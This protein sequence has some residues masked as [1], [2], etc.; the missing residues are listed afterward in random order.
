MEK[1]PVKEIRLL[2]KMMEQADMGWWRADLENKTFYCSDY[3]AKLF[4]LNGNVITYADF[5]HL[6][7]EDYRLLVNKQFMHAF[8][9]NLY[10]EA[11]P[12]HTIQG[13]RWIRSELV[14]V[15]TNADGQP[16]AATGFTKV[17]DKVAPEDLEVKEDHNRFHTLVE[18]TRHIHNLLQYIPVGYM[19]VHLLSYTDQQVVDYLLVDINPTGAD[20]L[21]R[22]ASESIGKTAREL[23]I[24]VPQ[25]SDAMLTAMKESHSE[26]TTFFK[27]S[28]RYCQCM[29]YKADEE[30]LVVLFF[31]VSNQVRATDALDQSEK[32]LRRVYSNIPVGI[33]VYNDKGILIELNQRQMD[34]LGISSKEDVL[35]VCLFD[36]P[37]LDQ[38]FLEKLER[39]KYVEFSRKFDFSKVGP[40]FKTSKKQ[41]IIDLE[42]NFTIIHDVKGQLIYYLAV[43]FD[44]TEENK[45]KN[46]I[47]EFE[48]FFR[49]AGEQAQVGYAYFNVLT[50]EGYAQNTWYRNIGEE[51]STPLSAILGIYSHLHPDAREKLLLLREET[52]T[53]E[54]DMI[55]IEV[56]VCRPDG[57]YTW[58]NL[59]FLVQDY[60][61]QERVIEV[62][63]ITYDITELKDAQ[64]KLQI[65]KEK[66]EEANR[67]KSA[68]LAN[69]SHEIRTPL[70]AIIGFSELLMLGENPEEGEQ[71]M[72][73]IKKNN[74]LL[75]QIISDVLDIAKIESG[76]I[77]FALSGIDAYPM[78]R[79]VVQQYA[80]KNTTEVQIVLEEDLPECKVIGCMNP[81]RQVFSNFINNAL[82]FTDAGEIT[83]GYKVLDKEVEFYVNDTGLGIPE[84]QR[85]SVFER[86]VKLH[87]FVPGTGLGLPIC[88]G[89]VEQLGGRIGVSEGRGGC[90]CRFW[91]TL[92]KAPADLS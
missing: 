91:F 60:R 24:N 81:L 57:E 36:N 64:S 3:L 65:A 88:K 20:F 47:R 25:Q 63:C 11:F 39:D 54:T 27:K 52:L 79:D 66:A 44:R 8:T 42:G 51:E 18:R 86:F 43:V 76:R 55:K 28:G 70:N 48:S 67:L 10:K 12:V 16:V 61:P 87:D 19:R 69:M 80:S 49:M 5:V 38:E 23:G 72:R 75:L 33:E 4:G 89:I 84:N 77:D 82:K 41:G 32:L 6:I 21:G 31:D 56:R 78:C 37:N 92:P 7:R 68:F 26:F 59:N 1:D 9:T 85:A 90:G 45:A 71:Y 30:E 35:G 62:A 74:E 50:K 17:I 46:K 73:I 53:G 15:E 58:T 29:L 13:E 34:V 2:H 22:S 83:L 40:Y 14:E